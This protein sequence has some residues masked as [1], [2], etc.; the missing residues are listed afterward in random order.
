[1]LCLNG[2]QIAFGPPEEALTMD[3]LEQTY[4]GEVIRL[5][6]D[7]VV[8]VDHHDHGEGPP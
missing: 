2:R 1:M 5:D 4:G 8:T 3:A 6:D 7:H